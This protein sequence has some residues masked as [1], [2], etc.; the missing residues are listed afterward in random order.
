L[1]RVND[2]R[3][4]LAELDRMNQKGALAG[5]M[6]LD[7]VGLMGRSFGGATTLA[8]LLLEPRFVAGM[9]VVPPAMPDLRAG[10]PAEALVRGRESAILAAEGGFALSSIT[11]PTLLLSGGEDSLIIGLAASLAKSMGTPAPTLANPHPI[12]RAAYEQTSAPVVWGLLQN[13]NHGSFGVSGPWWWPQLKPDTFPTTFDPQRSY[14]LVDSAT[15]HR[16]QQDKAL[17]LF[18][19]TLRRDAGAQA[20]LLANPWADE[21]FALEARNL[22]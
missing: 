8:G 15:A 2:L 3:A 5:L 7:R 10:L 18:D 17:A 1:Q 16:I 22:K 20:R 4:T 14:T 13:S 12:L 6:A 11:K 9:A 19:L 21:G